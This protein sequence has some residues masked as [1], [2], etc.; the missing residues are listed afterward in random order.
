M[1]F[2]W[3]AVV[4]AA[5][6]PSAAFAADLPVAAVSPG[7]AAFAPHD[8]SGFY[9][10]VQAGWGWAG[11]TANRADVIAMFGAPV[12]N[13]GE[14]PASG[15]VGGGTLGFNYQTGRVVLGVEGDFSASDVHGALNTSVAVPGLPGLVALRLTAHMNWYGT[16][17]VRV[18]YAFD[19][20]LVY[21]TGGLAVAQI[22]G[23]YQATVPPAGGGG[24][25]TSSASNTH[26][27]WAL[28]A[29]ADYAL[30]NR[31]SVK[32]D[33]LYAQLD[34]RRYNNVRFK[35]AFAVVRAGVNYRF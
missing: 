22:D 35:G 14:H 3:V 18:G 27:G 7:V 34:S 17:R 19:R 6:L 10:G 31:W 13:G 15:V 25:F 24:T 28:G 1:K 4:A 26:L 32:L 8:W 30:S 12:A 21:A 5:V 20:L 16:A 11:V 2:A 29:G 23:T 9:A 33:G